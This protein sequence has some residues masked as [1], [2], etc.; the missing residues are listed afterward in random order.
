MQTKK[1]LL[2][3]GKGM[4]TDVLY[5]ALSGEFVITAVLME[6]PVPK[7]VLLKNRIRRL[8]LT[9]VSG[10]LLF[11]L[12][13]EPL[14]RRSAGKRLARIMEEYGLSDKPVP[15]GKIIRIGSVNA[16][17]CREVLKEYR[18]DIVVVNGTRII[19]GKTLESV[20]A[21]FV[22]THVGITPD[23]R[24]VHGGYWALVNRDPVRCGVTVHLVDKGIDTGPILYQA[25]IHPER[26]DN[27]TT[28]PLIQAGVGIG[29]MKK[30]LNDLMRAG[31]PGGAMG[32]DTDKGALWTHPTLWGY[33]W[34]RLTRGV[35]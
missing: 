2:L 18:P 10:Q 5:N 13:L 20:P 30:A 12:L 1:I 15:E 29:L 23:Y 25:P 27:F 19:S 35:R 9:K 14:L 26:G 6:D 3:T 7:G 22:N 33:L 11:K 24:G 32:K 21:I 4:S 28:Y 31:R 16:D 8:G 34:Y 17:R